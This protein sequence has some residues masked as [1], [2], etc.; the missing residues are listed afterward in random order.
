MQNPIEKFEDN[1]NDFYFPATQVNKKH[2]QILHTVPTEK[3][4]SFIVP[5]HEMFSAWMIDSHVTEIDCSMEEA[6]FKLVETLDEKPTTVCTDVISNLLIFIFIHKKALKQ[7]QTTTSKLTRRSSY[8]FVT[9]INY[10]DLKL[11]CISKAVTTDDI[12]SCLFGTF[13]LYVV[14]WQSSGNKIAS[15]KLSLI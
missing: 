14:Q 6:K 9:G 15:R 2:F 8:N 10:G 4:I 1:P 13:S 7:L 11:Y 3:P 5:K 12:I